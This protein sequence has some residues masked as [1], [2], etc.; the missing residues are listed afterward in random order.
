[1][2]YE[3]VGLSMMS[4]SG[5]NLDELRIKIGEGPQDFARAQHAIDA[6]QPLRVGWVEVH[7]T[8]RS[9]AV[10]AD[11]VVVARHLWFWSLNGCRV[12]KR[13]PESAEDRR[14]GFAYGTLADHAESG[15]ELFVIELDESDGTVWYA[16]RAVSKPQA[17]LARLASPVSRRLQERFRIASAGAMA[18]A[19]RA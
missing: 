11:V 10:G 18:A 19:V 15:E 9:P 6:W 14:F 3:P 5:Y 4:P 8:E 16:I 1:L 2:T 12:V 17:V 7:P 13:F